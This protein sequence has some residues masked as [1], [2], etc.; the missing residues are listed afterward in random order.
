MILYFKLCCCF[1]GC[2]ENNFMEYKW[3]SFNYKSGIW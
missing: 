3:T 1:W 2:Y